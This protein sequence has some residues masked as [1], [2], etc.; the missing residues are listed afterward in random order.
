MTTTAEP[1]RVRSTKSRDARFYNAK[2][3]L[4][5]RWRE[6]IRAHTP[7]HDTFRAISDWIRDLDIT[8]TQRTTLHDGNWTMR[9]YA[10]MTHARWQLYLDGIPRTFDEIADM[11]HVAE[12]ACASEG[13]G[14]MRGLEAYLAVM[15]RT[16]GRHEWDT[17]HD[18]FYADK[19]PR[20]LSGKA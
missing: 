8:I 6:A 10:V 13:T 16:C 12:Q 9:D 1:N 17:S 4:V 5:V 14:P 20:L 7:L 2:Q 11:A 15:H 19:A 18:P 3:T